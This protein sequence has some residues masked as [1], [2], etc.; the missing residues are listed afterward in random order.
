MINMNSKTSPGYDIFI[1]YNEKDK[2]FVRDLDLRLRKAGLNVWFDDREITDTDLAA[3][4]SKTGLNRSRN[5]LLVMSPNTFGHG[6]GQLE[7]MTFMF[8][9]P[10]NDERRFIPLLIQPCQ[11]PESISRYKHINYTAG[12]NDW[13]KELLRAATPE[14]RKRRSQGLTTPEQRLDGHRDAVRQIAV[15]P[16]GSGAVS[17]SDDKTVRSWNI[18]DGYCRVVFQGHQDHVV[19]VAITPNGKRILTGSIDYT[20]RLWDLRHGNR[21]TNL[22]NTGANA[23]ALTSDGKLAVYSAVGSP[24]SI[25][26]WDFSLHRSIG[27]FGHGTSV[28]SLAIT[29]DNQRVVSAAQDRNLIVWDIQSFKSLT[30]LEG[31]TSG[32]WAVCIAPDG[33]RVVSGSADGTVKIWD[34]F[35]G[36]C[37]G[38]LEG[39]LG[40]IRGI[41]ISPDGKLIASAS[42]DT[43]IRIWDLETGICLKTIKGAH[44]FYSVAFTRDGSQILGGSAQGTIYVYQVPSDVSTRVAKAAKPQIRY[45]NAKVVLVGESGVGKS[46]LAFRL[47]ENRWVLTDSTHG[48]R[49]WPL[50]LSGDVTGVDIER[51]VWLW[52]LAGQPEYRLV[53]Q[54]FLDQTAVALVL[55]NPQSEDPFYGLRDWEEALRVAVGREPTKIL[56]AARDD[57]GGATITKEKIL[58]FCKT[59]NF[60]DYISTSAK[61]GNGCDELRHKLTN[62]IPWDQLPWTSTTRLFKALKDAIVYLKDEGTVLVRFSELRQ[63]LQMI[64]TG[65]FFKEDDLGVVIGLLAGQGIVKRLDFGEFILLQPEQLNNYAAAVIRAARD[66][67]DGIGCISEQ[68]VLDGNFDFRGMTRLEK[69]DE[70]ILLRAMVQTFLD[71][72]LCIREDTG[73]GVQLVFPSQFNREI[74]IPTHPNAFICYRFSGHLGTIYTTLVVRLTY[75]EGFEKKDLWK[76]AAEFVTPEG[77]TVGLIM[78]RLKEGVGEIRVFF[79]M[80]V[81]DDTRVTFIKYVHEHLLKRATDVERERIYMCP[82]CGSQVERPKAIRDRLMRGKKDIGCDTCDERI[83]LIDLI[84]QKLSDDTFL[85]KVQE[86]DA[87]ADINLDNESREL[88]LVGQAFAIAGEAGQIYRQYTNSDHGIDGEIEFKNDDGT[89]SGKKLYLQLKS[90]DSYIYKRQKDN[91]EIFTV[92]KERHLEYWQSQAYPVFL[93]IR[94]SR[95]VIRWMNIS[96]Y[97]QKRSTKSSKQILFEGKPFDAQT[98][99]VLRDQYL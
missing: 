32:V 83:P 99:M 2:K 64:M 47:A 52:D 50:K 45:T 41:A 30:K 71:Q 35:S 76:N 68:L 14:Q 21:I 81:P 6:W 94:S 98:L 34:T 24:Y 48:M 92:K 18:Q 86:L 19:S 7:R 37:E 5:L 44:R 16:D 96:E 60:S 72:S 62:S 4:K 78:N 95:G 28:L 20:M 79:A 38:T 58:R 1:A 75:S 15:K 67:V 82:G 9:N 33:K 36:N 51:E 27:S 90:G 93:V 57:R 63:R 8:R 55:F 59:R 70:D 69:A 46:G 11:I 80:G 10:R 26:V 89:A 25:K 49:V 54:L 88:I 84:E 65:E 12:N 43:T 39:H 22:D 73:S 17:V 31:H 74:E 3:S 97:L 56:V 77:K 29:P 40:A 85:R 66:H 87:Q 42:Y 13:Y 91:S 61:V 23:I 53:H